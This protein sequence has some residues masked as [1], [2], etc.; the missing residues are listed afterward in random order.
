MASVVGQLIFPSSN[1]YKVW[2]DPSIIKW[3]KR[4]AHVTL[5]C[6]DSVEGDNDTLFFILRYFLKVFVKDDSDT[7]FFILRYF[8]LHSSF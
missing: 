2:E 6:H 7:L 5:H 1:G 8:L 4:D 3:R